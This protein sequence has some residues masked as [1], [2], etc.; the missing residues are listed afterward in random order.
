MSDT[1]NDT[2]AILRISLRDDLVQ[3][4]DAG[5]SLATIE[6][7]TIE[8]ADSFIRLTEDGL[9]TL[10][11]TITA[12]TQLQSINV[13]RLFHATTSIPVS[14]LVRLLRLP[15]LSRLM[16]LRVLGT[17]LEGTRQD[18]RE[19][20]RVLDP[21]CLPCLEFICIVEPLSWLEHI[22]A[23]ALD[24]LLRVCANHSTLKFVA[25]NLFSGVSLEAIDDFCRSPQIMGMHLVDTDVS[26]PR[27][28]RLLEGLQTNNRVWF[29]SVAFAEEI[30][31]EQAMAIATLMV[32]NTALA[33]LSIKSKKPIRDELILEV[34][35]GL[36]HT[37]LEEFSLE[38]NGDGPVIS[39]ATRSAISKMLEQNKSI[40]SLHFDAVL[41]DGLEKE[42]DIMTRLNRAGRKLLGNATTQQRVEVLSN[43]AV[44]ENLDCI[45]YLLSKN[46]E[47][48]CGG[49]NGQLTEVKPQI[50][51]RK[52]KHHEIAC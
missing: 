17:R 37:S 41:G 38:G 44:R 16:D 21:R 32:E 26:K 1:E 24:P 19:L 50:T 49:K 47:L 3:V 31:I 7:V 48:F 14:A 23:G 10:E 11:A 52:R 27:V 2:T 40:Q 51:C 45:Y 30:T 28:L 18:W 8:I 33:N 12:A 29:L 22:P 46:P 25:S 43:D 9:Q 5:E 4:Q 42:I 13:E 35:H 15:S 34:V 36:V 39:D 6:R 20:S